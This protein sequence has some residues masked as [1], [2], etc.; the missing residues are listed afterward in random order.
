M[1][2]FKGNYLRVLSPVTSDGQIPV[3]QNG[4]AKYKES[5]MAYGAAKYL[6]SINKKLPAHLKHIVEKVDQQ[7]RVQPGVAVEAVQ[8]V[9][10]KAK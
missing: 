1:S 7:S 6:E 9:D 8:P 4:Q 5:H 2:H 3:M 10:K